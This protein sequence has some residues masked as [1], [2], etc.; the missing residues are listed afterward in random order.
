MELEGLVDTPLYSQGTVELV[1]VAG[2]PFAKSSDQKGADFSAFIRIDL[3][4]FF[5]LDIV[6]ASKE[7][8]AIE[9][10]EI[11]IAQIEM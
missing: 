10:I 11:A 1:Q 3:L 5:A 6:K 4:D 7:D 9:L 2:I 8:C